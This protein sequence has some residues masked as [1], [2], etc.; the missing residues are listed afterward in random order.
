MTLPSGSAPGY[1][2]ITSPSNGTGNN[3]CMVVHE[4]MLTWIS[5]G[6]SGRHIIYSI[7]RSS[8][9][10]K[11]TFTIFFNLNFPPLRPRLKTSLFS[12]TQT[13]FSIPS[14]N[15]GLLRLLV[16]YPPIAL[17]FIYKCS[18]LNKIFTIKLGFNSKA[19]GQYTWT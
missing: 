18:L 7:P 12:V 1:F 5:I 19:C 13:S 6:F 2:Q 16:V 3:V 10:C 11:P 8:W 15:L 9:K 14:S 4:L 17:H